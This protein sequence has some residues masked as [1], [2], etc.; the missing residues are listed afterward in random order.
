[1]IAGIA[2]VTQGWPWHQEFAG[3][4]DFAQK[5]GRV[6]RDA[7]GFSV[8]S[9]FVGAPF[10][11]LQLAST[12]CAALA[13]LAEARAEANPGVALLH[14]GAVEKGGQ[15]TAFV[16]RSRAGKSTLVARLGAEPDLRI[17][18]DDMLPVEQD[19][20]ALALGIA[21]RIRLPLP[22]AAS[23]LFRAH[24]AN[25]IG[26]QDKSYA[27]ITSPNLAK[28]GARGSL[29]TIFWL[30]RRRRGRTRVNAV[31]TAEALARLQQSDMQ[32]CADT[33]AH[34]L[35]LAT[36]LAGVTCLELVYADLEDAVATIRAVLDGELVALSAIT[37][38]NRAAPKRT[39]PAP[40]DLA[41]MRDPMT[42]PRHGETGLWLVRRNAGGLVQL[43]PVGA[44]VWELLDGG[45][46]PA[47]IAEDISAL[48]PDVAPAR[49]AAD[50]ALLLGQMLDAGLVHPVGGTLTP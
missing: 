9:A 47:A 28:H 43:N 8:A 34:S 12:V 23:P 4:E 42:A 13:D 17:Y 46:T 27:Y 41:L 33:A 31:A 29:K 16:G 44:A 38:H 32:V 35:R 50:V 48:F 37:S 24:V 26:L 2:A 15:V 49:I 18:C 11:R 39:K 45:A 21:P 5:S 40:Q 6:E 36:I 14:A 30:V 1:M 7:E 3:P 10:R 20:R 25:C 22:A 19:G